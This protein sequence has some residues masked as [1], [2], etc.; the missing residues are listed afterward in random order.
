ML[1]RFFAVK[2]AAPTPRPH[3]RRMTQDPGVE[4]LIARGKEALA[5]N[6]YLAAL[7]DLQ[8]AAGQR[9][10]FADVQNMI[11]LC[12]SMVGRPEEA[13]AAFARATELN[14]GYVEAHVNHAITLNDL[15]RVDEA[16]DAFRR[17]ADADE[18]KGG[19]G[20]FSSA[21]AARLANLHREL[22]DAYE[23]AG[24]PED[25]VEQY[26]KAVELRPQFV[27]IRTR[28]GRTLIELGRL[29]E[30]RAEL[31][32]V[33]D[34]NPGFVQARSNLGLAWFRAG[35]LDQAEREWRRCLAQQPGSAQVAAYLGMLERRRGGTAD[36]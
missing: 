26:R 34:Q 3:G 30:A 2:R 7:D 22:A 29:D 15:G 5:R 12:L 17:A 16:R 20:R 24:A 19:G 18:Q 8:A 31:D 35:S 1:A 25:A 36:A 27:D 23:Q 6:Q 32:A 10:G 9:P 11:G 33:L 13:L 21:A 14:P 28:L 4:Q